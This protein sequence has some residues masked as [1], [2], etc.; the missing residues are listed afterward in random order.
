MLAGIVVRVVMKVTFDCN[1]TQKTHCNKTLPKVITFTTIFI[2]YLLL[3]HTLSLHLLVQSQQ[4][5]H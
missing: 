3:Y 2:L 5:E 1:K 4:Q